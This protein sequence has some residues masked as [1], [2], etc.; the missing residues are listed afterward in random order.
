MQGKALVSALLVFLLTVQAVAAANH[1]RDRERPD[2]F[3]HADIRIESHQH[4]E[5]LLVSSANAV[6]AGT[7]TEGVIIVDGT[8]TILPGAKIGGKIIILGGQLKNESGAALEQVLWVVPPAQS[9]FT[10]IVLAGLTLFFVA[11]LIGMPYL[12]WLLLH[13]ASRFPAFLHLKDQ[14]LAMR[15]R[16]P[17]LYIIITLVVSAWMLVLFAVLAWQTIFRQAAGVFDGAFIWLIRYFAS[18]EL[19]RMMITITNLGFGIS[20]GVMVLITVSVLVAFRRWIEL[21]GLIICLLGGAALNQIL[22]LLFERTRPEVFHIIAA[23]GFSFPSGHAMG[24]LCFYGMIAFFMIRKRPWQWRI[25]GAV[26][27]VLLVTAIGV[28]RIYLGVHYPSDVV[29]GYAAGATWLGFSISLVMWWEQERAQS[30]Q[31]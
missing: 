31:C 19:D 2:V 20:Y 12:L 3:A 5:R 8:L 10:G 25:A 18:P 26:A 29:A 14:L 17:A 30:R 21:K 7:I 11:C 15:R 24:S 13:L 16:W 23:S 28:S 22:K 6:V 1:D 27:A 4:I 9:P